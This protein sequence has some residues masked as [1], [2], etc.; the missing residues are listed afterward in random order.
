MAPPPFYIYSDAAM[1]NSAVLD[2]HPSW[3]FDDQSAEAAM[4]SLLQKH[5]SRVHSPDA[6]ELFVVPS[7]A[8]RELVRGLVPWRDA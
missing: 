6:A 7:Y 3:R 8:V 5:P 2:C 1:D 4:L